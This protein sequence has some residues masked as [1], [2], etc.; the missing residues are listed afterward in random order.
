MTFSFS[1]LMLS[2]ERI[3]ALVAGEGVPASVGAERMVEATAGVEKVVAL[4]VEAAGAFAG[5]I[6]L[7]FPPASGCLEASESFF[8]ELF[9]FFKFFS[10][11][12][13]LNIVE[14]FR[15]T[16]ETVEWRDSAILAALQSYRMDSSAKH[17]GE[18]RYYRGNSEMFRQQSFT[19]RV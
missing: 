5:G 9:P 16:T 12:L 19:I 14:I 17:S 13:G 6:S 3:A 15:N 2:L 7:P 10:F 8:F 18:G 1:F 11:F 4:V